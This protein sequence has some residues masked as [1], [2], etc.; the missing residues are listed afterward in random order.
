MYPLLL[1]QRGDVNLRKCDRAG[2]T[3]AHYTA[4]MGHHY[5]VV[6]DLLAKKTDLIDATDKAGDTPL[7][8][9]A[10]GG[11]VKVVQLLLT[12]FIEQNCHY[13]EPDRD[14][15]LTAFSVS[16]N[17]RDFPDAIIL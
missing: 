10:A 1:V 12:H 8:C 13:S 3:A 17:H 16:I 15:R 11:R 4:L 14:R 2:M 7:H 9:A 6:K 5:E